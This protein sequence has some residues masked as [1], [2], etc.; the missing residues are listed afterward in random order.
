MTPSQQIKE[1]GLKNLTQVSE[2]SA[3]PVGTLKGW[4]KN[5]PKQFDFI[6]S[7]CV[8]FIANEN[9]IA[10]DNGGEHF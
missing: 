8:L 5:K 9:N 7:S 1:A 2:I 3:I 10:G 6:I 4:H